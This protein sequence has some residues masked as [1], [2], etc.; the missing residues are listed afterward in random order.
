[1]KHDKLMQRRSFLQM[2]AASLPQSSVGLGGLA[3]M[4]SLSAQ[5]ATDSKFIVCLNMQG[6]NDQSNTIIP[7]SAAEYAAYRNAR[8]SICLDSA[9][10]LPISPTGFAGPSLG[11]HPSLSYVAQLFNEG[12]AAVMSNVGNLVVPVS[13]TQWNKGKPT[14]PVPVQIFSHND[15]EAQWQTTSP[16]TPGATGWMGRIADLL[17][18]TYSSATAKVPMNLSVGPSTL[19]LTGKNTTAYKFTPQGSPRFVGLDGIGGSAAAAAALR[20]MYNIQRTNL[21]ESQLGA[22]HK[23]SIDTESYVT[24]AWAKAPLTNNF[25]NTSLAQ[26]LYGV[27]RMMLAAPTLGHRRQVFYVTLG[28]YDFHDDLPTRQAERLAVVNAAVQ[29]FCTFLQAN[30]LWSQTVLF[31]ASEF[32]R[33]LQ[34]NGK[35]SDHGWG[36]HHFVLGGP[37]RGKQVYGRWPTVALNAAEDAG[38]GRLLP[39]T[40]IDQYAATLATWFGVSSTDLPYVVPNIGNFASSNLGFLA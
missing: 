17:N 22:L 5:T 6:G 37:V 15:Q 3:A 11:L 40:S 25:P 1:M 29:A 30:G 26:Q 10:T 20:Q 13:L 24:A 21:L 38:Q 23:R 34:S 14:V 7:T 2:L 9:A 28:G 12:K 27:A 31:T 8:P 36:S 18:S 35:G 16:L 32:G 33:A 19:M 39:T 4:G